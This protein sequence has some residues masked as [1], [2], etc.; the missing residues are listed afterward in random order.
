MQ[1]VLAIAALAVILLHKH[2]VIIWVVLGAATAAV[3]AGPAILSYFRPPAKK[4]QKEASGH[5]H[6][7]DS[8]EVRH[9]SLTQ[10]GAAIHRDTV[11]DRPSHGGDHMV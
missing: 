8:A 7:R 9:H 11:S 2:I 10:D 1:I 6:G 3:C 4:P 5:F